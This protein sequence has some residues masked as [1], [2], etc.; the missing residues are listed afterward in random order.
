MCEGSSKDPTTIYGCH[1]DII[2]PRHTPA[3][4]VHWLFIIKHARN[5]QENNSSISR[6]RA[7]WQKQPPQL[8]LNGITRTSFFVAVTRRYA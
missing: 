1:L 7:Y 4:S 6:L 5:S 2:S 8:S 3:F